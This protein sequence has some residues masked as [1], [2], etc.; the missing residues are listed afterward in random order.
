ML[1]LNSRNSNY[2]VPF[3]YFIK[4]VSTIP[5][6]VPRITDI[7]VIF[8]ALFHSHLS[9]IHKFTYH[10]TNKKAICIRQ[11]IFHK[12]NIQL[13]SYLFIL[14][15]LSDFY[16]YKKVIATTSKNQCS[17]PLFKNPSLMI[18]SNKVKS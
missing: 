16:F 2:K 5:N 3:K 6:T 15:L 4:R 7:K 14:I 9:F 17:F 12:N 10:P 8:V 11:N 18:F 1:V 13:C